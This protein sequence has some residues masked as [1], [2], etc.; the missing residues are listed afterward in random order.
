MKTVIQRVKKASVIINGKEKRDISCGLVVLAGFSNKDNKDIL[1]KVFDKIKKMRIF[2]NAEGKFDNSVE[3]INGELLIV[4]QFTL[5]ANCKKGNRPDFLEAAD[6]GTGK[7]LYDDF[8]NIAKQSGL[9]IE[10]GEFGADMQVEIHNDGPVT[11][12][13]DSED[14]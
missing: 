10:S 7:K 13:L 11:I 6:F 3:D 4:S 12:V 8:L 5:Y 1:N 14:L 2:S 9:K